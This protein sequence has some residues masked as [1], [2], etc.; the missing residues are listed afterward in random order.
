MGFFLIP[1]VEVTIPSGSG[2]RNVGVRK[3]ARTVPSNPESGR[4]NTVRDEPS[5]SWSVKENM[6]D[7]SGSNDDRRSSRRLFRA[8]ANTEP[9][10]T[11]TGAFSPLWIHHGTRC[12]SGLRARHREQNTG[13]NAEQIFVG[14]CP[15]SVQMKSRVFPAAIAIRAAET[16]S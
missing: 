3:N 10:W 5:A 14:S 13:G 16:S 4:Q 6:P 11:V 2:K 15:V 1:N 9:V 8:R 12:G 7:I